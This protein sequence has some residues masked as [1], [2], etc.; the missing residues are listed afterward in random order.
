VEQVVDMVQPKH[1]QTVVMVDLVVVLEDINQQLLLVP[2]IVHQSHHLKETLVDREVP[3]LV[4][5]EELVEEEVVQELLDLMELLIPVVQEV[6][7]YKFLQ[8]SKI[9]HLHQDLELVHKLEVV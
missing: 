2:E 5:L 3:N 8:H 9:Q 6:L 7:V 4:F 1:G